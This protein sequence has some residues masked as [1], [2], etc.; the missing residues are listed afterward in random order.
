[1]EYSDP[2]LQSDYETA[3]R[4]YY[5]EFESPEV[6]EYMW[7]KCS[8]GSYAGGEVKSWST[9]QL[10]LKDGTNE[11]AV[12]RNEISEES[13]PA[14]FA[15][16]FARQEAL[17]EVEESLTFRL[18]KNSA[19][20]LVGTV[21][22]SISDNF[23]PRSGPGDR[24]QRIDVPEFNRGTTLDVQEQKGFW[25][26]VKPRG[27]G[28]TFWINQLA[29]RPIPN[30]APEDNTA[31]ITQ[32]LDKGLLAAYDPQQSMARIAR[33]IWAGTHPAIREGLSRL[34]AENSAQVRKSTTE[35]IEIK[36]SETGRRLAR[37]SQAQGFRSQ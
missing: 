22:Y 21:R 36:D 10:V 34:L 9:S 14:V 19:A 18:D 23:I 12:A 33:G 8:D 6:G 4:R 7:I 35:W 32:L 16:A 3:W 24:F 1:M 26:R 25:I 20:A 28:E 15:D 2:A 29:T 17:A 27:G 37:Y 11:V 5:P 31:L 30:S 13:L